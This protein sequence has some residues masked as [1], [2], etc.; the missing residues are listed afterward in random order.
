MTMAGEGR[1]RVAPLKQEVAGEME[2]EPAGQVL[3]P[4]SWGTASGSFLFYKMRI[5]SSTEVVV[6]ICSR[7]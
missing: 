2:K 7:A 5:I 3:P 1:N 4:T 6:K